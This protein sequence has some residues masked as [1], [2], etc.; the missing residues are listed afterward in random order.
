VMFVLAVMQMVL[1]SGLGYYWNA[2]QG[3]LAGITIEDSSSHIFGT[4]LVFILVFIPL[5]SFVFLGFLAGEKYWVKIFLV[6]P[7]FVY[8][9]SAILEI[10]RLM[11]FKEKFKDIYVSLDNAIYIPFA[12]TYLILVVYYCLVLLLPARLV[13]KG[14][15]IGVMVISIGCYVAR[16]VYIAY[17][18][19]MDVLGGSFG[20]ESFL[21]YLVC[22]ALD[23]ATYFLALSILMTHC[24]TRREAR[25]A[26]YDD[27]LEHDDAV[28]SLE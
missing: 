9:I 14:A 19:M 11:P 2:L 17:L 27:Q 20:A 4:V 24:A 18:Q 28:D 6:V 22:F 15:G 23:A 5:A 12:V 13:T 10:Q 7:G 16:G 8:G 25:V 26:A 1:C 3:R 21:L